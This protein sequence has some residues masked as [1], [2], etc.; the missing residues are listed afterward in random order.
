ML[1][2]GA[3]GIVIETPVAPFI[4]EKSPGRSLRGNIERYSPMLTSL[5]IGG[6]CLEGKGGTS[7]NGSMAHEASVMDSEMTL[8]NLERNSSSRSTE[9]KEC[10]VGII[11]V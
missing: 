3:V 1:R 5:A 2:R 6:L 8:G 4:A 11:I 7:P 9:V 10:D